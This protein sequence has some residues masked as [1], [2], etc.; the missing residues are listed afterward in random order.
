MILKRKE[1]KKREKKKKGK[2]RKGLQ[3]QESMDIYF[4]FLTVNKENFLGNV[5]SRPN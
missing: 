1:K 2:R 3:L 5:D 4:K